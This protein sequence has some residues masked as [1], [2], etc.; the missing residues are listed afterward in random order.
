MPQ[1]AVR[2]SFGLASS[3]RV[4]SSLDGEPA[5]HDGM[6]RADAG[7]GQHRDDRFRDHRHVDDDAIALGDAEI[8][9]DG[10]KRFHLRQQLGVGD[11]LFVA[12]DRAVVDDGGLRAAG[13]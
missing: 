6:D 3:M 1:E 4:A 8:L 12:S 7:A 10:G 5:E 2:I 13:G 11:R 9:Q